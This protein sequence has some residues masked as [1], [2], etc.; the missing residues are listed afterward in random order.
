[1]N[2][3]FAALGGAI[4]A[5]IALVWFARGQSL[6]FVVASTS[7][8]CALIGGFTAA[9]P[10]A[11]GG[12]AVLVGYGLLV[13]LATPLAVLVPLPTLQDSA[14]VRMLIRR[15]TVSL[16]AITVFGATFALAGNLMVQ[17]V[18]HVFIRAVYG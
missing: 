15:T 3:A 11:T 12:F 1:M 2:V 6:F 8:V 9:V 17:A 18:L 10:R 7:L 13:T 14:E 4:G 16:T 5:G